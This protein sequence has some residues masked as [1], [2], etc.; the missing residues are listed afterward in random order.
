MALAFFG[1]WFLLY[2]PP[3]SRAPITLYGVNYQAVVVP[4]RI[5]LGVVIAL[6][7]IRL[8][9]RLAAL[10]LAR[11]IFKPTHVA[12]LATAGALSVALRSYVQWAGIPAMPHSIA[13]LVLDAA[14]AVA[15]AVAAIE[16]ILVD[17]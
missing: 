14:L 1:T 16:A 13:L 12:A 7:A 4:L 2:S 8:L 10:A 11:Q 9:P 15:L 6:L 5:F 3:W 17:E